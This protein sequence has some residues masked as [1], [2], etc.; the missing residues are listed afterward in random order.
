VLV[1]CGGVEGLGGVAFYRPGAAHGRAAWTV[2]MATG[3][4]VLSSREG[5]GT[6]CRVQGVERARANGTERGGTRL[7]FTARAGVRPRLRA[8]Q[9]TPWLAVGRA[10]VARRGCVRIR[11]AARRVRSW[12]AGTPR[13]VRWV[14]AP[15]R[16]RWRER[17]EERL[18]LPGRMRWT[19]G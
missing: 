3:W 2:S 1:S 5:S 17:A 13:L 19:A 9:G 15:V 16:T 4:C 7:W 12:C 18:S 14:R 6:Q 8:A 10:R 11:A